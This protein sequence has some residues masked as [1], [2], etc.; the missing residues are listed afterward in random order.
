MP[1]PC[2][3]G[4]EGDASDYKAKRGGQVDAMGG[5][6]QERK[7]KAVVRFIVACIATWSTLC[8][9]SEAVHALLWV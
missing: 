5:V 8:H 9:A 7:K 1:P 6:R 4:A 3:P 2:A